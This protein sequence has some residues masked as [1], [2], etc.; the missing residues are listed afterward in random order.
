M[1]NKKRTRK[2]T[3]SQSLGE[4]S[5]ERA[6]QLLKAPKLI[7]FFASFA[8]N[9]TWR[10]IFRGYTF[11]SLS[12]GCALTQ[13]KKHNLAANL[14][15]HFHKLL[16]AW[17]QNGL[18]AQATITA[19]LGTTQQDIVYKSCLPCCTSIS[20]TFMLENVLYVLSNL[21]TP[22]IPCKRYSFFL[23]A[24]SS[25]M[26]IPLTFGLLVRRPANLESSS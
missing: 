12:L 22:N 2:L 19:C 9:S 4:K 26:E 17:L 11:L 24:F 7:S 5:L 8:L 13:L 15:P 1:E 6:Q 25:T 23:S 14:K 20:L 18:F 21:K 16:Q 10:T 3:S